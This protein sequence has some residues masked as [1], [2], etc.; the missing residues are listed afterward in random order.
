MGDSISTSSY[1]SSTSAEFIHIKGERDRFQ[2]KIENGERERETD[3]LVYT[4]Y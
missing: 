4:Y 3:T 1:N 2:V